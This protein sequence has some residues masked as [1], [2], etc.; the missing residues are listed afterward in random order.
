MTHCD[1]LWRLGFEKGCIPWRARLGRLCFLAKRPGP[2]SKEHLRLRCSNKD[3]FDIG[4]RTSDDCRSNNALEKQIRTR[5][6][7]PSPSPRRWSR[8]RR[9]R[10]PRR[11]SGWPASSRPR[12]STGL[13]PSAPGPSASVQYPLLYPFFTILFDF[14]GGELELIDPAISI[15]YMLR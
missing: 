8:L 7:S 9:K 15:D 13:S 4:T 10:G 2:E 11:C 5:D 3:A 12:A 6:A 14:S 1:D